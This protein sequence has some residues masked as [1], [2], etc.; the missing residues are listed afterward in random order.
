MSDFTAIQ[1]AYKQADYATVCEL[2]DEYFGQNPTPQYSTLRQTIEHNLTQGQMPPPAT[3]QGLKM[4]INRL[5]NSISSTPT[6]EEKFNE[7]NRQQKLE[8]ELEQKR[9]GF[10]K[11]LLKFPYHPQHQLLPTYFKRV[12]GLKTNVLLVFGNSKEMPYMPKFELFARHFLPNSIKKESIPITILGYTQSNQAA[13]Y[14]TI[15]WWF[16]GGLLGKHDFDVSKTKN[17]FFDLIKQ[18]LVEKTLILPYTIVEKAD[19]EHY[20]RLSEFMKN[21]WQP[22]VEE[23]QKDNSNYK[24]HALIL[25]LLVEQN[26]EDK[27]T[28]FITV[29]NTINNQNFPNCAKLKIDAVSDKT[30]SEWLYYHD[31]FF[32]NY[33]CGCF[34]DEWTEAHIPDCKTIEGLFEKITPQVLENLHFVDLLKKFKTN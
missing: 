6:D 5:R 3:L 30:C 26:V 18:T 1:K 34:R 2:L 13:D 4:L 10:Y 22:L 14:D 28:D 12:S 16:V 15:A 19:L 7:Q 20:N 23:L 32:D 25:L 8:L 24:N 11:H 9:L 27:M 21:Y 33:N 17:L 29:D 31:G